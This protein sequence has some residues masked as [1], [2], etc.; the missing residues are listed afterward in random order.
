MHGSLVPQRVTWLFNPIISYGLFTR[1]QFVCL[2]RGTARGEPQKEDVQIGRR[3]P[4]WNERW[5]ERNNESDRGGTIERVVVPGDLN[6]GARRALCS[7]YVL[8]FFLAYLF[9]K[10]W[11]LFLLPCKWLDPEFVAEK[12]RTGSYFFI[13]RWDFSS[14][15]LVHWHW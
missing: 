11:S 8:V 12:N 1:K 9:L 3:K 4:Y 10:V 14:F 2:L 13:S 7:L 5:R 6:R 15:F